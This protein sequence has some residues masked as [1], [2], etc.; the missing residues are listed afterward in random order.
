MR[1]IQQI[2][3]ELLAADRRKE[4]LRAENKHLTVKNQNLQKEFE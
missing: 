4:N 3:F 2:K 1:E